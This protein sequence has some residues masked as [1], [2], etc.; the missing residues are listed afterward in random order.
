MNSKFV[1]FALSTSIAISGCGEKKDINSMPHILWIVSGSPTEKADTFSN[2]LIEWFAPFKDEKECK[3]V[4]FF[5]QVEVVR[6]DGEEEYKEVILTQDPKTIASKNQNFVQKLFGAKPKFD[7]LIDISIEKIKTISLS[8][9]LAQTNPN[10]KQNEKQ[11]ANIFTKKASL[12]IDRSDSTEKSKAILEKLTS[13]NPENAKHYVATGG[14]PEIFRSAMAKQL[15]SIATGKESIAPILLL[16]ISRNHSVI[17]KVDKEPKDQ[18]VI[19]PP[20]TEKPPTDTN[21]KTKNTITFNKP[22]I[23]AASIESGKNPGLVSPNSKSNEVGTHP[24]SGEDDYMPGLK[25]AKPITPQK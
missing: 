3:T 23:A 4:R 13:I 2:E 9:K 19:T 12:I 25:S 16:D 7:K 10:S 21:I 14:Q 6:I 17:I 20:P 22:P 5:P 15:C 8:E 24:P 11:L 18:K 1:L